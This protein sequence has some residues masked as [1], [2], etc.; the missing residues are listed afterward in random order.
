MADVSVSCTKNVSD[1]ARHPPAVCASLAWRPSKIP[2]TQTIAAIAAAANMGNLA[3]SKT[4][5]AQFN[6][7]RM[8]LDDFDKDGAWCTVF[9]TSSNRLLKNRNHFKYYRLFMAVACTGIMFWSI[10]TYL[11]CDSGG[12]YW[13]IYLTHWTIFLEVLY[14][15]FAWYT[16]HPDTELVQ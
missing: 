13:P 6:K 1:D 7:E 14:F 15:W 10:S 4:C 16:F 12:F 9:G 8:D 11:D 3:C 5:L 2:D